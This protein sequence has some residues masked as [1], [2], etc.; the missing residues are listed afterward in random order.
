MRSLMNKNIG[1]IDTSQIKFGATICQ[2]CGKKSRLD[3][4]FKYGFCSG[5]SA[6]RNKAGQISRK[7]KLYFPTSH[8]PPLPKDA[9]YT[10]KELSEIKDMTPKEFEEWEQKRKQ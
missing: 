8:R 7:L 10:Y 2:L 6:C 4:G 5:S 1:N 3:K 9:K